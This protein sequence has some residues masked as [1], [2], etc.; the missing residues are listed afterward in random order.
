M[1]VETHTI[2]VSTKSGLDMQDITSLIEERL[3]N[4]KISSG[5]VT[6]FVP[7]STGSVSTIE[8]EPNL[9]KDFERI[10]E[11]IA[12]SDAEYLHHRTWGDRNGHSHVRA[13]L[14]GPSLT[15]PFKDKKLL[16]GT[17]QQIVLL[18]FDV[19]A[20]KREIILQVVGE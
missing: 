3:E 15:V 7:G 10:M 2:R 1:P 20:R 8:Y 18:D 11:K 9:L 12:P 5:I 14:M 19:P 17:W 4:G 6:I 16:L 13:S